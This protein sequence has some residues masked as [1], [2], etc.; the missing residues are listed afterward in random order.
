MESG[1][2]VKM[3]FLLS[4]NKVMTTKLK[5]WS[6]YGKPWVPVQTSESFFVS[7]L[8]VLCCA[9]GNKAQ[10]TPTILS[11]NKNSVDREVEVCGSRLDYGAVRQRSLTWLWLRRRV[12]IHAQTAA[13]CLCSPLLQRRH[14]PT[15]PPGWAPSLR[16]T[17]LTSLRDPRPP[18]SLQVCPL[19]SLTSLPVCNS[20]AQVL[21]WK[22]QNWL[23]VQPQRS[24]VGM[25]HHQWWAVTRCNEITFF[26]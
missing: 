14:Q 12:S 21:L 24:K 13:Q 7:Q 9:D 6:N 18:S 3:N 2:L 4:G 25:C 5:L 11:V 10:L 17:V 1:Y 22:T 23:H 26:K 19:L 15:V 20:A 16:R 8:E